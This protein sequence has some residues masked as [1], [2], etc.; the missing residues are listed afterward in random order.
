MRKIFS[1]ILLCGLSLF[2]Q[3]VVS[4]SALHSNNSVGV[5]ND[6]TTLY[7]VKG[8]VTA[9]NQVGNSATA[10]PGAIQDETAGITVW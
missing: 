5:P 2:G 10:G 6:T 8:V 3:T 4:I 1:L 9:T 7:K